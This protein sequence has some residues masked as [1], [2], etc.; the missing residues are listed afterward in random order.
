MHCIL[1]RHCVTAMPAILA[2]A[3]SW[4]AAMPTLSIAEDTEPAPGRTLLLVDDHHVL[5]RSGTQRVFHAATANETNPIVREEHAWEMAIAWSSLYRDPKTGKYQLWYQA[6]AGGRD[7]RKTHRCVVCYAESEDGIRFT[8]PMLGLHDFKTDRKPFAG[9]HT[10]TNIVLL[11]SG[12]YGDRYCNSVLVDNSEPN[13][14]RRYKMLYYDFSNDATG[15]EWPGWHAAFSPDGIHWTKSSRNPLNQTA[16]GGRGI[17][18]YFSDESPYFEQWDKNKNFLRKQWPLPLSMSD[19]VDVFFDPLC[20]KYVVYGKCWLNGPAGGL[21]WKHAMARAESDDFLTWS[22][23]QIVC[24]PDDLDAPNTEFHTSPVFFHNGCYFSLNQILTARGET[25]GA[26][27]DQ[28]QIELMVSRDG[29]R[30][31]RPFRGQS[32]IPQQGFSSGGIF[33]NSTPIILDDEI[34]FYY[35]GYSSGATGG[36][37]RLTSDNQ[38]S[39]VGFATIPLD[40]FAGI[41]SAKLSAQTTLKKPLKDI[42][43]VTL[44]PVSLDEIRTISINADATDGSIHVE[45]LDEDG[46]RV[47][48]FSKEDATAITGDSLTH[49]LEWKEHT[50]ADLPPGQYMLRLHLHNAEIFAVTLH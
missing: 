10:E 5:Y 42:G 40:R 32:F 47:R 50:L 2:A 30:W 45:I 35:G 6:Y 13:P 17:Q 33:T 29:I 14:N 37:S 39:G 31:D 3:I 15:Q 1:R 28:M 25:I 11:A 24:T 12:G 44:K 34:R 36:G 27:A 48:G 9:H 21:A 4:L 41:R 43:Q 7:D 22:K 20:Q 38:Q 26:K 19:A 49:R 46:F 16:Y 18:P 8:K 23:P